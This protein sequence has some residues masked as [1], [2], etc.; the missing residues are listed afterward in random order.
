VGE[1]SL[2]EGREGNRNWTRM[3]RSVGRQGSEVYAFPSFRTTR[4]VCR[5]SDAVEQKRKISA[6]REGLTHRI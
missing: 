4:T 2:Q 5:M 6:Q 3:R 1:S